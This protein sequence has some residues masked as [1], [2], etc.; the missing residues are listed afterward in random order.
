MRYDFAPCERDAL[1]VMS[2]TLMVAVLGW[3]LWMRAGMAHGG[4]PRYNGLVPTFSFLSVEGWRGFHTP[5]VWS[6]SLEVHQGNRRDMIR[7]LLQ[8]FLF[9]VA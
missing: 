7:K 9:E 3:F 6:V 8:R 5:L 4:R 2:S 1:Q